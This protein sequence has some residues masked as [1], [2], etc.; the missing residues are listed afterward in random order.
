MPW[1][2][3]CQ[4]PLSMA[5]SR[6]EYRS[7]LPFSSPRDLP[8]PGIKPASLAS[9]ALAGRFFTTSATWEANRL[10]GHPICLFTQ[11]IFVKPVSNVPSWY[12]LRKIIRSNGLLNFILNLV[13]KAGDGELGVKKMYKWA[14]KKPVAHKF[15]LPHTSISWVVSCVGDL[16]YQLVYKTAEMLNQR[17]D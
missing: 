8:D 11:Q 10:W 15:S 4:A 9:P 14:R 3:G 7:G 16:K 5:F 13:L 2:A 17:K 12:T 1:F 6:Q